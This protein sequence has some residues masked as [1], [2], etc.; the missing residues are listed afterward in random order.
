MKTIGDEQIF[1]ALPTVLYMK[2]KMS[3]RLGREICPL[4]R[5]T[6]G[7]WPTSKIFGEAGP[8]LLLQVVM[9]SRKRGVACQRLSNSS[10]ATEF[11]QLHT[12]NM[13]NLHGFL[14]AKSCDL[15][16]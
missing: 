5:Y 13:L 6:P 9:M 3:T 12:G 8:L 1:R 10:A 14:A 7:I 2:Y 15:S 11:Q 16:R 4:S